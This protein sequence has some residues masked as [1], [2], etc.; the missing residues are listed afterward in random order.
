M[1][2]AFKEYGGSVA[3]NWNGRLQTTGHL[4]ARLSSEWMSRYGCLE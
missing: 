4:V 2:T 1:A 3:D